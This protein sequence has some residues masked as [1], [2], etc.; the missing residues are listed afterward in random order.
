M[1]TIWI[2][3]IL[4]AFDGKTTTNPSVGQEV[5]CNSETS[6]SCNYKWK[7]SDTVISTN[8]AITTDR[9]GLYQ[10]EA[11]CNIRGKRCIVFGYVYVSNEG[12]QC[13]VF[14]FDNTLS[15]DFAGI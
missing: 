1:E 11:D 9:T 7:Y 4:D 8:R 10:C 3:L 13:Q 14:F 15:S 2:T 5:Q 12:L 6:Q